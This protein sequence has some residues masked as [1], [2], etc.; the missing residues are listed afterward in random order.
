MY[1]NVSQ[2]A[3]E[4]NKQ[5]QEDKSVIFSGAFGTSEMLHM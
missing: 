2:S 5:A 3:E 1:C 4:R